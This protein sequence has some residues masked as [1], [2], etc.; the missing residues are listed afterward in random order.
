MVNTPT[1]QE[2]ELC[3]YTGTLRDRPAS[4]AAVST[5]EGGV[6][7]VIFDGQELHHLQKSDSQELMEKYDNPHYLYRHQ[8]VKDNR[9]CGFH[10]TPAMVVEEEQE[11]AST[12]SFFSD[13]A[14]NRMLRY[15]RDISELKEEQG[16]AAS[17]I[18]IKGPWNANK[19]SRYVELVIVVDNRK[20]KEYGQDLGKVYS[21]CKDIANIANA[22]Y[23]PLNIYIALVGV[24]VWTEY[25]EIT[26]STNADT[27]LTN[28]L[29]YRRE[30]LVKQF[31][32]DNAQLLTGLQFD[33]G[34]VGKAL[35]G[36]ICTYEFS[37]GV[38]M[39]HSE[40]IGLVATTMAHEMG[41]NFGM[42]H[43]TENCDCPD[44]RCIMSP[45][46]STMR[47]N[48]WSSCSLEYLAL[49]FEHGES[50]NCLSHLPTVLA[51]PLFL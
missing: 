44:D 48:F 13:P 40:V 17:S 12:E 5:C 11:E 7:G 46:S 27:T 45:A 6:E 31:P 49:A 14:F 22:L 20:Y 26:L 25:D 3:H 19:R 2:V 41:H 28:F 33:S 21:K 39:W 34:V 37:G 51:E 38:S 23:A 10:D 16:P 29:H 4:W 42:E 36:P 15:K 35:K 24:D 32:N 8:E 1:R 47:P 9:T 30:R 43:D 50:D 18:P